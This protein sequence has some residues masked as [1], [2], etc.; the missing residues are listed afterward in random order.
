[1]EIHSFV[2]RG[3]IRRRSKGDP[4][5][6]AAAPGGTRAAFAFPGLLLVNT[7]QIS[8]VRRI[9][10]CRSLLPE[11][12]SLAATCRIPGRLRGSGRTLPGRNRKSAAGV[13][14]R[15]SV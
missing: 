1:M 5:N 9:F 15:L 11:T 6:F 14:F 10:P 7:F 8:A 2:S 4:L 12:D 13:P 3:T